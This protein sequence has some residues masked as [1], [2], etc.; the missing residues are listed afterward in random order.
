M[1]VLR[2]LVTQTLAPPQADGSI[3]ITSTQSAPALRDCLTAKSLQPSFLFL[4]ECGAL[5]TEIRQ[6][7]SAA[8]LLGEQQVVKL[9]NSVSHVFKDPSLAGFMH[10]E[11]VVRAGSEDECIHI[12]TAGLTMLSCREDPNSTA[13]G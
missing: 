9:V 11:F 2:S 6:V 7:L 5:V 1:A 4:E 12:P 8:E 10:R 13:T 3:L